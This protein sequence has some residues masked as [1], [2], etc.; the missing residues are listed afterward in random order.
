[1]GRIIC[2]DP[3]SGNF[4]RMELRSGDWE[5]A[6]PQGWVEE[7]VTPQPGD[8]MIIPSDSD[9]L[10]IGHL[11]LADKALPCGLTFAPDSHISWYSDRVKV[12]A[13]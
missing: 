13:K 12:V 1:M 2:Y 11:K 6:S 10:D 9:G 8:V 4:H 7:I 3:G 5:V